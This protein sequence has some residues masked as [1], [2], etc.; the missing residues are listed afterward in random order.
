MWM[1]IDSLSTV[2]PRNFLP[3][4][5]SPTA[6]LPLLAADLDTTYQF[7][8]LIV[9]SQ[10]A[11]VQ[12]ERAA[13]S[14]NAEAMAQICAALNVG[15]SELYPPTEAEDEAERIVALFQSM[16]ADR[17]QIALDILAVLAK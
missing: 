15:I 10:L 5:S 11:A 1:L 13:G 14:G 8:L 17:R 12:L 2:M 7:V 3:I 6:A 4:V 9:T 16:P